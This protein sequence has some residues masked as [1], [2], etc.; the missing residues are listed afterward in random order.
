[1]HYLK[2]YFIWLLCASDELIIPHAT[3]C[4]GY[5]VF[6]PSVSQSVSQSVSPVF[7]VSAT[8]LKPLKG[9]SWTFVVMKDIM[10]TC[11]YPQEIMIPIF[12]LGFTP[13]LN[14]K[15]WRKWKILRKQLVSRTSLKPLNRI[16]WNFVG[17]NV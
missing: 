13:F 15:I 16:A 14:F 2:I 4:G 10:C 9:I 7:L 17:H 8:P 3:S 11:A 1:M 6:Y 5:N 12:F